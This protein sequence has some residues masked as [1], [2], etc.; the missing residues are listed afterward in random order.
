MTKIFQRALMERGDFG[1]IAED[2]EEG[3]PIRFIASTEGVAR[4]GWVIEAGGWNLE[5]YR[6][7]PVV[8]WAHD[9]MG[10]NLPVGR[11]VNVEVSE[12]KLVA[13]IQFDRQDAFAA[14]IE[15]KYR[16]GFL[17]AVS[18]GWDTKA[19]R[20]P[21]TN[22]DAPH[23]AEAELLDIS[24]VPVPGDPD[25]LMQRQLRAL[26]SLTEAIEMTTE[27]KAIP[28]HA[29]PKADESVAWDGPGQVAAAEGEEQ[30]RR[31]HAWV[32]EDGDPETKQSYKLP[33]HMTE[34]EV[35]WRGVAAAMARLL[36]AGTQIPDADRRGVY[37]HL[38]RHY[39]QFDKTPPEF[40]SN[41]ELEALGEAERRGLF[42]EGEL[43]MIGETSSIPTKAARAGAML[44]ARNK[45]DLEEAM[46]LIQGVLERATKE[47]PGGEDERMAEE[48]AQVR[49]LQQVRNFLSMMEVLK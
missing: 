15:R 35:V 9:Y 31:M 12:G 14:M 32:D 3:R 42:L 30:L 10:R 24:A 21:K 17:S 11:A 49:Q 43:E 39:E 1:G 8:L 6:K 4:D 38:A 36:Q 34:G 48:A 23:I 40:R 33:H 37:N 27:R 45:G 29:T 13:D 28:P 19:I 20:P 16:E 25:A 26:K 22:G 44:S 18:V 47:E 5:N 46:R 41:A 2:E 7:N